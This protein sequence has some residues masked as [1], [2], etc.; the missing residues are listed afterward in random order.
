[1]LE[2]IRTAGTPLVCLTGPAGAGRTTLLAGLSD[3]LAREGRPVSTLRFTR[4]GDPVPAR[5]SLKPSPGLLHPVV[6]LR[7]AAKAESIWAL[8]GPV[9]GAS[10]EPELARR[11]AT[12]AAVALRRSGDGAA[13][14]ID[15]AQW[16]DRDS[17]AVLEALVRKLAGSTALCVCAARVPAR[18]ASARIGLTMLRKLRDEGLATSLRLH[19]MTGEQIG[20]HASTVLGAVPEPALIERIREISRG[21]PAAVRDATDMLRYNSSIQVVDRRAYLVQGGEP[22]DPALY[23]RLVRT[24]RDLGPAVWATAKAIAVLA[25]L[26]AAVPRLVGDVL[27]STEADATSIVDVLRGEGFLHVGRAGESWRFTVPLVAAVLI[28][29]AGPF[30]RQQLAAK[31]V[32]AVW[33]GA[34]E[35]RDPEYLTNQVASAGRL[36]DPQRALGELLS[37]SAAV[38]QDRA[39]LALRWLGASTELTRNRAQQ[40]MILLMQTSTSHVHG[41]HEQS[42]RGAQLLLTDFAD[43]LSPDAA[44]EVQE[45][46]ICALSSLGDTG[47]LEELVEQ[48]RRWPGEPGL[49]TVTRAL[50]LGTLDRWAEAAI[51]LG[52]TEKSWRAANA[53]SVALGDLVQTM[54][55]LWTGRLD[56]LDRSLDER[57][58]WPLRATRRRQIDQVNAHVAAL[59]VTGDLHRAEELLHD[60]QVPA[61]SVHPCNHATEAALRGQFTLAAELARRSVA[62]GTPRSFDAGWAGMHNATVSALVA[63]GK[64]V[65]AKELLTVARTT[66]PVLGHLLDLAEAQIDRALGDDAKAAERIHASLAAASERGLLVGADLAWS[67]LAD[68]ALDRG[69]HESARRSLA[70]LD[71]VAGA[72]PTERARLHAEF[73]R[74]IAEQDRQ[75]ADKCLQQARKRGQPFEL[76]QMLA[77]LVKHGVVDPAL[78]SE[79]Y[80]ILGD[81]GALLYRARTRSLMRDHSVAVPGR[82]ATVAE[83]EHLLA[84]LAAEGLSNKQIALALRTSEKS[85]EGR[86]SRLFTRTGY[87]SR[88]E[89]SAAMLDGGLPG[90]DRAG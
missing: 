45:M 9:A 23:G 44:Q 48:R 54:A 66:T 12:S 55:E 60:E 79:A 78:L 14:L 80:A 69:D 47:A 88:I 77:K 21:I 32:N 4:H 63:Q 82:Q 5:L 24:I 33:T 53:T 7:G 87:R 65:T 36:V 1:M 34:A 19:P 10:D 11:V 42:L 35:C 2:G 67:E 86:L 25:P 29:S 70:T 46:A 72:M 85:V 74:A 16:M 17:L 81:L 30:E 26:G 28:A 38:R 62:A 52:S 13:L 22:A 76:A 20:R 40:A 73:A 50:A 90:S 15:D 58:R 61:E 68:L 6:Q 31:V 8:I 64:L 89:L 3:Q 41:D 75:A 84:V 18:G 49:E 37:H 57:A 71:E 83:N 59:L 43:Q 39:G 56:R 27:G 51:L